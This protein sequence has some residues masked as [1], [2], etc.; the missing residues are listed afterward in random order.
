LSQSFFDAQERLQA[1]GLQTFPKIVRTDA[2]ISFACH[3]SGLK[4]GGEY[5]KVKA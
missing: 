4:K 2:A 5:V 3:D 1:Q